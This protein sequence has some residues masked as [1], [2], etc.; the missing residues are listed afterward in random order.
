[1]W[2]KYLKDK[3]KFITIELRVKYRYIDFIINLS[4]RRAYYIYIKKN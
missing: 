3:F 1:M 4:E 2:I